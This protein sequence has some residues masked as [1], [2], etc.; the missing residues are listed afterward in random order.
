MMSLFGEGRPVEREDASIW[1]YYDAYKVSGK[2]KAVARPELESF[3]HQSEEKK[4]RDEALLAKKMDKPRLREQ[5]Q[6]GSDA[7]AFENFLTAEAL[8]NNWFGGDVH[9]TTMYDDWI[10]GV[11]AVVE[12]PSDEGG[13]PIRMAI[14]FT[15]TDKFETF[16]KKSD[17]LEGNVLVKYFRSGLEKEDG[18]GKEMRISLP[19]VLLGAGKEVFQDIA[20]SRA[21]VGHNHPLR[22]LLLEQAASQIDLQLRVLRE[23][24]NASQPA[25]QGG[26]FEEAL[27]TGMHPKI[28]DRY[29]DLVRLQKKIY[30]ELEKAR[31]EIQGED[32]ERL[33]TSKTHR[34]LAST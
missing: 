33:A 34:V 29:Q 27:N 18:Q 14:D 23:A 3:H 2:G 5:K 16:Y 30:T 25:R 11:D 6:T 28:K 15:S 31:A 21:V 26:S 19:I 20:E 32:W 24:V 22:R 1:S 12:W 17:K 10:S 7:F 9:V 8:R 13:E 4:R